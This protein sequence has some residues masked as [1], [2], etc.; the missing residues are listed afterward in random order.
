MSIISEALWVH[1]FPASLSLIYLGS[2]LCFHVGTRRRLKGC[3][4]HGFLIDSVLTQGERGGVGE[5]GYSVVTRWVSNF[6]FQG[7]RLD[8]RGESVSGLTGEVSI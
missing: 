2:F 6:N 3:G 4:T 1:C 5:R 7:R 8:F